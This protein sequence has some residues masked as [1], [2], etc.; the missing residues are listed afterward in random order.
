MKLEGK[1]IAFG[2]DNVL[3]ALKTSIEEMKKIRKIG[4]EVLPIMDLKAY[5]LNYKYKDIVDEIEE[6]AGKKIIVQNRKAE[7]VEGDIMVIS[8]CSRK[9][10]FK[11]RGF[12]I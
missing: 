9:Y 10:Y 7:K 1:I 8:P 4:G 5:K 2:L 6:I 3:Y 12:Y 11:A